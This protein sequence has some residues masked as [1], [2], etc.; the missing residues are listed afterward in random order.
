MSNTI[1]TETDYTAIVKQQ[2]KRWLILGI[3]CVMLL[4]ALIV[5]L[6]IRLEWLTCLIS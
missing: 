1:Y 5:S 3:P 4:V 6:F 2:R